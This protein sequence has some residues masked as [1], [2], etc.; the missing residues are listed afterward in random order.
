MAELIKVNKKVIND[1]LFTPVI[2]YLQDRIAKLEVTGPADELALS[3]QRYDGLVAG[4]L[5]IESAVTFPDGAIRVCIISRKTG[6]ARVDI[7][8]AQ[9]A[10]DDILTDFAVP[11]VE[12]DDADALKV[13][14]KALAEPVEPT[15]LY[16]KSE[17]TYGVLITQ[18]QAKTHEGAMTAFGDL[19]F[20]NYV[21]QRES[22]N[23]I[24]WESLE[25]GTVTIT[26]PSFGRGV[27]PL[28]IYELVL[29][30]AQLP[31]ITSNLPASVTS[32]RGESFTIP[33]TY[34]FSGT[35]DITTVA[36]VELST[37]AGY[38]ILDR[39]AD[40]LE[41]DGNT[42]YGSASKEVT[43]QIVVRVTYDWNGRLV[44]KNFYIDLLIEKDLPNDLTITS[45]PSDVE[46][47][48]GNTVETVL[49]AT[50]KGDVVEILIPPA[51]LKSQDNRTNLSYVKTNKDLSMV[52][53]GVANGQFAGDIQKVNALCQGE[54][55]YS[56]NGTIV[57]ATGFIN[58]VI[59][60]PEVLPTFSVTDVPTFLQG[61]KGDTGS[62]KP[63]IKYGDKVIPLTDVGVSTGVQGSKHLIDVTSVNNNTGVSWKIVEDSNTPGLAVR[64]TFT[65]T[66]SWTSETGAYYS[67]DFVISV[68]AN[69]DS[70]I[71]V[72]PAG[73]QPR[74]V[75]RYQTGGPTFD[76]VVNGTVDNTVIRTLTVD[77]LKDP[78]ATNV[79]YI[80]NAKDQPNRWMVIR[81]EK[82]EVTY[83]ANFTFTIFVDGK[84]KTLHFTQQFIIEKYPASSGGGVPPVDP[85]N[86]NNPGGGVVPGEEGTGN[87]GPEGPVN[88]DGEYDPTLPGGEQNANSPGEGDGPYNT[89]ITAVPTSFTM[90][91]DS[92]KAYQMSFKI[93]KDVTDITA[94][95]KILDNFTIVPEFV[96]IKSIEY[97]ASTDSYV[98]SYFKDKGGKSQGGIFLVEKTS[99]DP[100]DKK[101]IARLWLNVDIKQ[102]T[103]LKLINPPSS[104]AL[105]VDEAK[106]LPISVEFSG[107]PVA[108][109]DANLTIAIRQPA[110]KQLLTTI[111]DI[112]DSAI[113]FLNNT[114]AQVGGNYGESVPVVFTYVDPATGT[115]YT[116]TLSLAST[117]AYPNMEVVYDAA[118]II[119]AKIWDT[120]AFPVRLMAGS[121][122][123]T[124]AI[125]STQ[126]TTGNKYVSIKN[127][128]W[129]VINADKTATSQIVGFKI[130]YTVGTSVNQSLSADFKFNL[131]AWDGVTFAASKFEPDE[132]IA[133][134]G[135]SGTIAASF[136]YKGKDATE[137]TQFEKTLSTIPDTVDLGMVGYDPQIGLMIPFTLKRGGTSVMKLVFSAPGAP[138][139]QTTIN[140]NT[141][142][143][144][145]DDIN[146]LSQGSNIRGYYQDK[147]N[148]PL[149]VLVAQDPVDLTDANMEVTLSSGTGDP[150]TL[151]NI[152]A[153]G[154]DVLLAAGGTLGTSYNYTVD[155]GLKY[156]NQTTGKVYTKTITVPATIRV[157]AVTVSNNPVIV[158][159]VF[160]HNTIPVTLADERGR[161]VPITSYDT[162]GA[163]SN[164]MF[165][166]PNIWYVTNGLTTGPTTGELPL[167]LGYSMG[168][169][170]YTID[171]SEKFTINKWDGIYY[172]ATT[173][174]TK[175]EGNAGDVGTI[176]FVFSYQGWPATGSTL[177]LTRS[178]VPNNIN[179]GSLDQDG[180]LNYT[181]AGQA[182][183]DLVLCFVRPNPST[184]QVE[185]R[186]F[187]KVKLPVSTKSS[188]L[189]F[190]LVSNDDA[191]TLDWSKSG[192]INV[193]LKYGENEV[194]ANTPGLKFTL[195]NADYHGITIT[196]TTKDGIVVKATRSDVAGS[197][198]VYSENIT[199]SYE[200]G[201]PDPKTVSFD[202]KAT[203]S[204]GPVTIS[205]NDKVTTAIWNVAAFRQVPSFNG[206]ELSTVDH[207]E[208]TN[209]TTSKY[210]EIISAKNYEV[211]G[212]EPATTTQQVPTT[213]YY[214]VDSTPD[215]Q[216]LNFTAD[217]QIAGSTSVR[218]KVTASPTKLE[219]SLDN[220]VSVTVTPVYKDKNVGGSAK[221]KPDLSTIP[222]QLTLKEY[223]VVGNNYVITFTG[224]KAGVSKMT[225]VFWSPDAGTA[226]Q[227]RDVASCDVD[228][229]V[230][231]ELGIEIGNRDN[232][233]TGK[234]ADTGTYAMQ[235]LFGGIPIDA[236][237]AIAAGTLTATREVGAASSTNANVLTLNTWAPEA[238]D[239]TLTGCVQPNATVNVSDFINLS[240]TYGG[241]KYTARV[242]IPLKYTSSIPTF[243]KWPAG[244]LQVFSKG[245]LNPTSVCDGVNIAPGIASISNYGDTDDTYITLGGSAKT[246][247][248]IWGEKAQI[249]H[250]VSTRIVGQYRNWPW[251]A[252]VDAPFTIAAWDQRTWAPKI[253]LTSWDT[254]PGLD[255]TSTLNLVLTAMYKAQIY[256]FGSRG[257][258]FDP[259]VTDLKGLIDVAYASTPNLTTQY[260][261]ISAKSVGQ[262][263]LRLG[264]D[265]TDGNK[266][267]ELDKDYGF[268]DFTVNIHQN[269]LTGDGGSG[270]SGGNGDTVSGPLVVRL[271]SNNSQI[272]NINSNLVI[273]TVDESV[274]KITG[275]AASTITVQITAPVTQ[276]DG[277]VTVP[278][279]FTYTDPN[280]GYVTRGTFNYPVTLKRPADWPVVTQAVSN[281]TIL[282]LWDYGPNPF[283]VT[284][285]GT[286]VT[287]QV[288]P[289][290]CVDDVVGND[291]TTSNYMQLSLDQPVAG[292]WFWIT[293]KNVSSSRQ[294]RV[295]KW[296]L[297]VPYR[298]GTVSVDGS[299]TYVREGDGSNPTPEF[300]GST[301][302]AATMIKNVGDQVEVPF[303]LLWRNYKYSKG[304]FQPT[305]SGNSTVKFSDYFKVVSQRYDDTD[306]TTYLKIEATQVYEGSMIF[307]WDKADASA[308]P[309]E[310]VDRVSISAS[311]YSLV[312]TPIAKTWNIWDNARL[313]T[314]VSIKDGTTEISGQCLVN[315]INST[316][317]VA[318]STGINP[319]IQAYSDTAI[320]EQT[321]NITF[322]IQ[323][324][325]AYGNRVIKVIMPEKF[326]AYD[327]NEFVLTP[328]GNQDQ[329]PRPLGTATSLSA[330][331]IK[332]RGT[333]VSTTPGY[334]A[335]TTADYVALNGAGF[336]FDSK[337]V[338]G[339]ANVWYL[340]FRKTGD[341]FVGTV[342]HPIHY[343]GPGFDKWPKGTL[344]KNYI[345]YPQVV[346]FYENVLRIYPDDKVPDPVSGAFNATVAVPVKFSV[347]L[348]IDANIQLANATGMTE[349]IVGSTMAGLVSYS[350]NSTTGVNLHIDY[351]NRGDDITVDVPMRASINKNVN[352]YA[353]SGNRDWTQKVTI[354]GSK[355]GDTTTATNVTS[356][357]T[358]VWAVGA[359][360][361]TIVNNGTAVPTSKFKSVTIDNNGYIR[362]PETNPGFT[363][364]TWECYNGD[365]AAS[366]HTVTFTVVFNDG[367]KD[368][369]FTQSVVFN[370]AAYDGVDLKIT[371]R[372]LSDF[373]SG[374]IA[375]IGGGGNY[376]DFTG[377][378]RGALLNGGND[379]DPTNGRFKVWAAKSNVP[380][381]D[382]ANPTG[383][384]QGSTGSPLYYY[385]RYTY[386]AIGADME[387]SQ[388]GYLVYGLRAKEN[389]P[390]AVEGKDFIKVPMPYYVFNTSR[391]YVNSA[392]STLTGKYG[393]GTANGTTIRLGYSIRRGISGVQNNTGGSAA[394]GSATTDPNLLFV[395]YASNV[396]Y[397]P[398]WFLNE[399]TSAPQKTTR[400]KF[401][402]NPTAA[403]E[404]Q[405]S[406]Y[407]DVTQISNY[408]FPTVSNLNTVETTINQS[409]TLPF[410]LTDDAGNDI[411]NQA[412]IFAVSANDYIQLKDGKWFCYNARTGDTTTKV[413]LTYAITYK[414]NALKVEQE[415]TYL[416]K[417]YTGQPTAGDVKI[418]NAA[419]WDKGTAVPFTVYMNNNPVPASWITGITGNSANGRVTVPSLANPWKVI[420]GDTTKAVSD[421]VSYV[422][423]VSNGTLTWTVNQDVIFNIA[424]YDGIEFKMK[425]TNLATTGD[426]V[427]VARKDGFNT[428]PPTPSNVTAALQGTYRGEIITAS[429][430]FTRKDLIT[431]KNMSGISLNNG[432]TGTKTWTIALTSAALVN[433]QNVVSFV[434]DGATGTV[435]GVDVVTLTIPITTYVQDVL[436]VGVLPESI[437]GKYGDVIDVIGDLRYNGNKRQLT[438]QGYRTTVGISGVSVLEIV[439]D[440]LT[441]NG[442]QVRFK[443]EVTAD[444]NS[445]TSFQFGTT[446]YP[447]TAKTVYMS[448][449]V[450]QK[451]P[452]AVQPTLTDVQSPLTMNLWDSRA[453]SFKV[454]LSGID[455]TSSITDLLP[456]N[457]NDINDKFEFVKLADKSWGYQSVKSDTASQVKATAQ[458]NV[459][460]TYQGKDYVI[461]GSVDLVTNVNNGS[462]PTNRFNVEM[463]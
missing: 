134:S 199:V 95:A 110:G 165:M 354:K 154:L 369:T 18:E 424:Q 411:T 161:S 4:D 317:L 115:S 395:S 279:T 415:V 58:I 337:G 364:R 422:V 59:V 352:N 39:S 248:V 381:F 32:R 230:M 66:Y 434:R 308:T 25:C 147:V 238:F 285:S 17:K 295:T 322:D 123:W 221:F 24:D 319:N 46:V 388:T 426:L 445:N 320:A 64:D 139:I 47:G 347:G 137:F 446:E 100:I 390:A 362:V 391:L 262:A 29:S 3:K 413:T 455:I 268:T 140:I 287:S 131:A 53:R 240:Y 105:K 284:S 212:A 358:S 399:L 102:K 355:Q 343:T 441:A 340:T 7:D 420:A 349:S 252:I 305:L 216:V 261:T 2:K 213:L 382:I 414:G 36:T 196:G 397:E 183:L 20:E 27:Y 310:G 172:R 119:D 233:I 373:N 339:A 307:V 109:N 65:Q 286:D 62:Y 236:Q 222:P 187:A 374:I 70:I 437:V 416:V 384:T 289:T 136:V 421:T 283:K 249:T 282:K 69:L 361:F 436:Q 1:P 63:V 427:Q 93:F 259:S 91:G 431:M 315:A 26:D 418:V 202:A 198:T 225:L 75:K 273:K 280:T 376:L 278:M 227:P 195:A 309:T 270:L 330:S 8:I 363:S 99:T 346:T 412:T 327:G 120:G 171:V 181:L 311:F 246:Y 192:T 98:L 48:N 81:A 40:L 201:A 166:V 19:F 367:Y 13:Y 316:L 228:V 200:V 188:N 242:E 254:Y 28:F 116:Q 186:D 377:T 247:E 56:D 121:K 112:S 406:F 31:E 288:V 365:K 353:I 9:V 73:Q 298:G 215:L 117:T 33:N 385:Q 146:I 237:A 456:T 419:V 207:F 38:A 301:V 42:I 103:V 80:I 338:S 454:M 97:D 401:T 193:K 23:S 211:I 336:T 380:A 143:A 71:S 133:S 235:I 444:T 410:K 220:D 37:K 290:S 452:P 448:V 90:A 332:F 304:V 84:T 149:K 379:F 429:P 114:W 440:S 277:P 96:T 312:V 5:V 266:P 345:E 148:F 372:N 299:F 417:G 118:Q 366:Q 145:P 321:V 173:T 303:K 214:K 174:T 438:D 54:F 150:I 204:M 22:E 83:S 79:Q 335:V 296:K 164:V 219:G 12:I 232:L 398:V 60:K 21:I 89:D 226:P 87:G 404:L 396:G 245:S 264:W 459:K 292:T 57:K 52:Y 177:D 231:G 375:G 378:Y 241:T 125:S 85:T 152:L 68:Q 155:I 185:G 333:G 274:M 51:T 314:L 141:D 175:L 460:V 368:I 325:A 74:Q 386:K 144:W 61:Y 158:A 360:P 224:A 451:A 294:T 135:D 197:T 45:V 250:N 275:L 82:T 435:E 208:L 106:A 258:S 113:T 425:I 49:T 344:G 176:P 439:P 6:F 138:S 34:T 163:G 341:Q 449:P 16:L 50:Y 407:V 191:I 331:T 324:P 10:M 393:D 180:K 128:T 167:R 190:T 203:V 156:T 243:D 359:L 72:V 104:L 244:A 67:K 306:G 107:K 77:D 453:L 318:T 297:N 122:D 189:P 210:I 168:G 206:T 428:T 41:I 450:T 405:S 394:L 291:G 126:L 162:S 11:L 234:N 281:T 272:Q 182:D 218:F 432:S 217:Y 76:V 271:A 94:D 205:K 402:V 430:G 357:S 44:H 443:A 14:V 229:Q 265:R 458:F 329:Q 293:K 111:T 403:V 86:P 35:Q 157:P 447:S 263:T 184:P 457:Q 334:T 255:G 88:A 326:N 463:M 351:D 400:V 209:G 276:A 127:L 151:D 78:S 423:T 43:D 142:V 101:N 170:D 313:N 302:A 328:F 159:N 160:D 267:G 371:M 356:P 130:Y 383:V 223:K 350:G 92:D 257:N 269:S 15:L 132:I 300:Q 178:T 251:S 194:P 387:T 30:E 55:S 348:N 129:E 433:A 462:I 323:L 108:L 389:D 342:K 153:D 409:G 260:Y 124:S 392:D 442:F 179:L 239:Y 370:I 169:A 461:G 253:N 408:A 256:S